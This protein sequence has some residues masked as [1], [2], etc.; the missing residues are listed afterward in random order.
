MKN[1]VLILY[2]NLI[3]IFGF[4]IQDNNQFISFYTSKKLLYPLRL[5]FLI[6]Y[7]L[8][9]LMYS[10]TLFA[11]VL[12]PLNQKILNF[13]KENIGKTVDR[14]ECWDLAAI[15]LDQFNAKW[16]GEFQ[17]GKLLN[18]EKDVILPGDIVQFF[19]VVFEYTKNDTKYKETMKQHTAIIY[20]VIGKKHYEIAHQNTSE[21]G[22]IVQTSTIN[23]NNLKF[24]KIYFYRPQP[25]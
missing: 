18:P 8:F 7:L 15:P 6:F 14:G 16:D 25:H 23:L 9:Q 19:D 22:R 1:K 2:K 4:P 3:L 24:G 17:F 21:W 20:K 13:V 11:Q 12:P 5:L 10:P